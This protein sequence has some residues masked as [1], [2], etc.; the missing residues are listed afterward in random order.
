MGGIVPALI[1]FQTSDKA[2]SL[3]S[4]VKNKVVNADIFNLLF[5]IQMSGKRVKLDPAYQS[6]ELIDE[7]NHHVLAAEKGSRQ[8]KELV[9]NANNNEDSLI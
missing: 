3:R 6:L 4:R 5:Y 1:S 8:L 2:R 7:K 9:A